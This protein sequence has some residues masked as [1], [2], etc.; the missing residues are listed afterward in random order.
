MNTTD[1]EWFANT[2]ERNRQED[3]EMRARTVERSRRHEEQQQAER[4][5]EYRLVQS[6]VHRTPTDIAEHDER[7]ARLHREL[8]ELGSDGEPVPPPPADVTPID[9]DS[10]E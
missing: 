5:V 2:Y 8:A 9:L 1:R 10:L 3:A 7:L 6:A 4:A